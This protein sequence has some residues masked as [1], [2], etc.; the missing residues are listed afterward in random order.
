MRSG[1]VIL[2]FFRDMHD[3]FEGTEILALIL[4]VS[5]LRGLSYFRL[6]KITRYYVNL[7]YEVFFDIVP[8]LTILCYSTLGFSFIFRTLMGNDNPDFSTCPLPGKLITED[9]TQVAMG[10]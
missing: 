2:L 9:L 5:L 7:I 6:L 4:F 1:L 3:L 8:F 10:K